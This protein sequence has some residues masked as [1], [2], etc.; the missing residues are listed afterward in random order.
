M[1]AANLLSQTIVPLKTSDTGEEAL[2]F[3]SDFYVKH[4]PIVNNKQLLGLIS[5]DDIMNNDIMEA[6]GSFQLSMSRP[7]VKNRDHIFEVMR[8]MSEFNLTVIPVVDEEDNYLGMI[9]QD[10][11]LRFFARIGSFTEP[12][13]IVVLEMS[14][15][16][17]SLAQISRVVES[18]NAAVLSSF[19]TTNL[20]STKIDVTIKVNRP[21][22]S[23]M[24][25]TFQRFDYTVKASFQESEYFE[26]LKDRYDSLMSFLNV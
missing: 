24:L 13:S 9:S 19:I 3:M 22:I 8:I 23:N 18:E 14:K 11:L 21:E 17:Y 25:A 15:Q 12:G 10:D 2:S 20:D 6:V 26:T 16:D 4:L 7:Y 5:E 1:I